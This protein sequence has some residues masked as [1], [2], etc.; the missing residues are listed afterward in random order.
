MREVDTGE[1]RP[2]R[3]RWVKFSGAS[4]LP[5]GSGFYYSRFPEPKEDSQFRDANHGHQVW[6]HRLG[7]RQHED[8][9]SGSV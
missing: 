1:D 5:D 7:T 3:I 9:L 4:W 6:L 2:D 8:E